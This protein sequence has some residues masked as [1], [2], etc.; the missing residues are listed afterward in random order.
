MVG[1][2]VMQPVVRRIRVAADADGNGLP[3]QPVGDALD[4][5]GGSLL[6]GGAVGTLNEL[7]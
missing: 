5:V 1:V 7:T 3:R 2:Q 4:G 6:A